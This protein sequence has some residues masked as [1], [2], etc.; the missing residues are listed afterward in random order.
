MLLCNS[1]QFRKIFFVSEYTYW[2]FKTDSERKW[3]TY[4]IHSR[5]ASLIAVNSCIKCLMQLKFVQQIPSENNLQWSATNH[6]HFFSWLFRATYL[7]LLAP[8]HPQLLERYA[9][10]SSWLIRFAD[11]FSRTNHLAR[12]QNKKSH[13][14]HDQ[15]SNSCS[16]IRCLLAPPTMDKTSLICDFV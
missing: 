16:G 7:I 6:I 12:K 13:H 9:H 11:S 8:A 14:I 2:K 3:S 15:W 1:Q 5:R 4:W 10:S